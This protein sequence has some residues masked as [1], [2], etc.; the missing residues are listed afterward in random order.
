MAIQHRRG[1]YEDFD[2]NKM[3]A[4]EIAFVLSGDPNSSNGRSV[5]VCFA[6]GVVKRFATYEDMLS[7]ISDATEDIQQTIIAN[8]EALAEEAV[9]EAI[10]QGGFAEVASSGDYNDLIN[11]PALAD[12][13]IDF[14]ISQSRTNITSGS[15]LS[16]IF[17]KIRRWFADLKT[18]AFTG[19]Y[20]DLTDKPDISQIQ[21]IDDTEVT[22]DDD[23]EYDYLYSYGVRSGNPVDTIVAAIKHNQ[24]KFLSNINS[25]YDTYLN[26]NNIVGQQITHN[27]GNNIT[28]RKI[29]RLVVAY[30]TTVSGVPSRTE[31]ALCTI[32]SQ[33]VPIIDTRF[34]II[35]PDSNALSLR[36]FAKAS[37]AM[38]IYNYST[39]TGTINSTFNMMWFAASAD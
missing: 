31:S 10:E 9:R 6:P 38:T 18:V 16:D 24:E 29:G 8:A 32:P 25:L 39:N 30:M 20:N 13:G 26:K 17:G 4:G 33:F 22:F 12:Q 36:V 19:S 1:A 3:L 15:S 37:G 2:P 35:V 7:S 5:Y 11:K 27:Y 23:P 34:D 21:S 14:T 28:F